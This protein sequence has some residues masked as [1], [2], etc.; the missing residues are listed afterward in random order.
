MKKWRTVYGKYKEC[1]GLREYKKAFTLIEM[2]ISL[3]IILILIGIIA[4]WVL[5][6]ADQSKKIK[7]GQDLEALSHACRQ[8]A[9]FSPGNKFP[10]N[11]G[12]ISITGMDSPLGAYTAPSDPWGYPYIYETFLENSYSVYIIKCHPSSP[13]NRIFRD[14]DGLKIMVGRE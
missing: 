2:V 8:Y 6:S 3:A 14:E 13:A 4:P 7:I 10:K 12:E 1:K 11:L 5:D 9:L